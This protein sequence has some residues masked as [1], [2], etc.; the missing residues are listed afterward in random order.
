MK[1]IIITV[2]D[3]MKN[4]E[5]WKK[6]P[7]CATWEDLRNTKTCTNCGTELIKK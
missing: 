5:V 4:H 7:K 6:C 2:K 3:F 1:K